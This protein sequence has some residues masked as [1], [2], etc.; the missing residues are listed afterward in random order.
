[1]VNFV[2]V[3]LVVAAMF[4][5]L[6]ADQAGCLEYRDQGYVHAQR[7]I[8]DSRARIVTGSGQGAR[9]RRAEDRSLDWLREALGEQKRWRLVTDS[10][11]GSFT[12]GRMTL[13]FSS[14]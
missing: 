13:S 12:R 1:M 4:A 6:P 3:P 7:W 14:C 10:A 5:F 8:D 2:V 9:R 11:P